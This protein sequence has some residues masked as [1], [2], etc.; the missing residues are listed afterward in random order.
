MV[1]QGLNYCTG[2]GCNYSITSTSAGQI[3]LEQNNMFG[4]CSLMHY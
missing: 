2:E 4:L 1:A 3:K